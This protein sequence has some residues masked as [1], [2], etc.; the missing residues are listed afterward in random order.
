MFAA[1]PLVAVVSPVFITFLL[2]KLS[3]IPLLEKKHSAEYKGNKEFEDYV[4][5]TPLLL[6]NPLLAFGADKK[7]K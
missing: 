5:R 6:P 2:F 7:S 4:R 1:A 3:G